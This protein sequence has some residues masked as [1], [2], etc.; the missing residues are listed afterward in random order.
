MTE[1]QQSDQIKA[2]T[3]D[4]ISGEQVYQDLAMSSYRCLGV[5]YTNSL[6]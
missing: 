1:P 2:V 3:D 5:C 4:E 6:C